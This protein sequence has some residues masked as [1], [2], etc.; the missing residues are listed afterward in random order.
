MQP[1][2]RVV[3]NWVSDRILQAR[4]FVG[5]L[6]LED[7]DFGE[8]KAKIFSNGRQKARAFLFFEILGLGRRSL[9]KLFARASKLFA[10]ATQA[11]RKTKKKRMDKEY[12]DKLPVLNTLKVIVISIVFIGTCRTEIADTAGAGFSVFGCH[13]YVGWNG[14]LMLG[15]WVTWRNYESGS[16][17]I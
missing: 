17:S 4:L 9:V 7:R 15:K 11:T 13:Y 1:G 16:C 12:R 6:R 14:S 10:G 5:Q 3:D 2:G 8:D